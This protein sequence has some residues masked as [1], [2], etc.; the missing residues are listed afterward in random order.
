MV[1]AALTA[2]FLLLGS[3][4]ASAKYPQ[5]AKLDV[6]A[7]GYG[8]VTSSEV[9]GTANQGTIRVDPTK[10]DERVFKELELVLAGLPKK[11]SRVLLC[12]ALATTSSSIN[13]DAA[14][15]YSVADES[16][17]VLFVEACVQL[18]LSLPTPASTASTHA[19]T[20]TPRRCFSVEKEIKIKVT[21]TKSG[22]TMH[23]KGRTHKP[24]HKAPALISC[25]RKQ[26]GVLL[27]LKPR[28]KGNTLRQAVGTNLGIG[29]VNRGN[30]GVGV[31]T[32][33]AV[34]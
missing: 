26:K 25:K 20:S 31:K 6:P 34:K 8:E 22:Y 14:L 15:D 13:D 5:I 29:F 10:G 33:F 18:A 9:P 24:T 17:V 1:V 19:A 30:K 16:L 7:N 27:T 2:V 32:T 21:H 3:G 12:V 11:G 23:V 28:K 4:V